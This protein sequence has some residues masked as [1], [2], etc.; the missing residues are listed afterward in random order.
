MFPQSVQENGLVCSL[1]NRLTAPSTGQGMPM[2]PQAAP[3][4]SRMP[5]AAPSRV[6]VSHQ[7]V[8]TTSRRKSL[9]SK[10]QDNDLIVTESAGAAAAFKHNFEAPLASRANRVIADYARSSQA[11]CR[12]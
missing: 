10:V 3:P 11:R 4:P 5:V 6:L 12:G 2:P 7:W 8:A 9:A 1:V